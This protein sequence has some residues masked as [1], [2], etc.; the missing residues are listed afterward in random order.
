MSD[1]PAK[2][3][4]PNDTLP[5]SL[6]LL[7]LAETTRKDIL[8]AVEQWEDNPPENKYADILGARENA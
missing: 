7:K 3:H 1:E 5:L 4:R 2:I 8:K 6:D